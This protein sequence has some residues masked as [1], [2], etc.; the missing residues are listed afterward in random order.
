MPY[1]EGHDSNQKE[2][3]LSLFK[4]VPSATSLITFYKKTLVVSRK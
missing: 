2:G 1:S 3:A 4:R